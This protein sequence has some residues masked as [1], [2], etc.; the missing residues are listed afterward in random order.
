MNSS[1]ETERVNVILFIAQCGEFLRFD[2]QTCTTASVITETCC[3]KFK[4]AKEGNNRNPYQI[5]A[6]SLFIAGKVDDHFRKVGDVVACAH[7]KINN[8]VF[9]SPEVFEQSKDSLLATEKL[10]LETIQFNIPS[11]AVLKPLAHI[12]NMLFSIYKDDLLQST[13]QMVINITNDS[14]LTGLWVSHSVPYI[15]A[16]AICIEASVRE[17][18]PNGLSL[19]SISKV[20]ELEC[21]E[22]EFACDTISS[23]Y[24]NGIKQFNPTACNKFND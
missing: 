4:D 7:F 21:S 15:V 3:T 18:L 10:V 1:W 20:F 11:Q 2:M 12:A 6:A 8:S 13:T 23:L 17:V 16:A 19:Q 22:L 24:E 5:A 14:L 9:E